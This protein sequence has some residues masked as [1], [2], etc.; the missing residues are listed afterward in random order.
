MR[1]DLYWDI[2][3]HEDLFGNPWIVVCLHFPV[4]LTEYVNQLCDYVSVA[5]QSRLN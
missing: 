4:Q 2:D 5:I 1:T 3:E